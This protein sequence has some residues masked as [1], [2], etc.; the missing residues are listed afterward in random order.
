MV[1]LYVPTKNTRMKGLFLQV[2][3]YPGAEPECGILLRMASNGFNRW[4]HKKHLK[5][6]ETVSKTEVYKDW[7]ID[8]LRGNWSWEV[9]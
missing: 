9:M 3:W 4:G 7:S 1:I 5:I 8:N 2:T 6:V